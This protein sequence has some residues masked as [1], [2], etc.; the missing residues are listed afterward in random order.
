MSNVVAVVNHETTVEIAGHDNLSP[1]PSVAEQSNALIDWFRPGNQQDVDDSDG[2]LKS[3]YGEAIVFHRDQYKGRRKDDLA[4][5]FESSSVEDVLAHVQMTEHQHVKTKE[6]R[7]RLSAAV[8]FG[9]TTAVSRINTFGSVIDVL[10]STHPEYAAPVWGTIKFLF[11]VTLCHQELSSK[12]AEAFSAIS[13]SLPELN[14]LAKQLYPVSHIQQTL[15]SMYTHIIDFCIRALKWYQKATGGVFKRAFAAMKNP[16]SLEFEDVVH[17]IKV[18]NMRIREQA[19]VAH[20]A[21]TRHISLTMSDVQLEV[22]NLRKD[23]NDIKTLMVSRLAHPVKLSPDDKSVPLLLPQQSSALPSIPFLPE[24]MSKYFLSIPFDPE[25]ALANGRAMRNLERARGSSNWDDMWS[26]TQL[27]DWI[28]QLGSAVVELQGLIAT[29]DASRHFAFDMIDLVKST[30]L[31]LTWFVSSRV[32]STS[33]TTPMT[34]T[35][36]LRSLVQQLL[37]QNRDTFLSSNLTESDFATCN[38]EEQWLHV[39][40][41]TLIEIPRVVVILDSHGAGRHILN[42]V[43]SFWR[44]VD[45]RKTTTAVKML[46]LTYP[47]PGALTPAI[48]PNDDIA[49]SFTLA[50]GPS[51][52]PGSAAGMMRVN[53]RD[54]RRTLPRQGSGPA[55]LKP[56]VLQLLESKGKSEDGS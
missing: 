4:K 37:S 54:Q 26:S 39:L 15:A 20:K 5:F 12:V 23:N 14:F 36:I 44:I 40:V 10:V 13:S 48:L 7:S 49:S 18:A 11:L 25:K 1:G 9:W 41:A 51:R 22:K 52:W 43:R 17:Q 56:F 6:G 30:E 8:S 35:D 16:W 31:P 32:P 34:V 19:D 3:A 47:P 42:A 46:L 45:E 21:E 38:T 33:S 28:S 2:I 24:K 50:L 55:Q 53:V 29:P 27:R